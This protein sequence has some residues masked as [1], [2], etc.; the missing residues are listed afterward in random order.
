MTVTRYYVTSDAMGSVTAILDGDGN[1]L[2]CRS[3]EAFGEMNCFQPDGTSVEASLTG[4]DVGFQGQV[5]D[6]V[7]GLYQM[8]FR[9]YNPSLGRWLSRDPIGLEGGVDA[10]VFV[11]NA[12]TLRVDLNGLLDS[13]TWNVPR[14]AAEGMTAQ[15]ISAITGIPLAA[16]LAATSAV[17][18]ENTV[19]NFK[20]TSKGRDPCERAKD[21]LER[22]KKS[23][24]SV[25]EEIANHKRYVSDPKSYPNYDPKVVEGMRGIDNVIKTWRGQIRK[26]MSQ[27]SNYLKAVEELEEFVY[28]MCRCWYN[29][30]TWFR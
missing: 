17:A 22:A 25:D 2:E 13:A 11:Q 29:P 30:T 5:S 26:Q 8:G 23:V 16:A 18:V 20:N 24:R 21:A 3:Y 6:E 15:E 28:Q 10:S 9:W 12:P 19:Q 1:V 14:M 27:R 4:V 7:T